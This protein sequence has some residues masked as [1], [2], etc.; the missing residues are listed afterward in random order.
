MRCLQ[1]STAQS[2]QC[3]SV[4]VHSVT[5]SYVVSDRFRPNR[6]QSPQRALLRKQNPIETTIL[7]IVHRLA[8]HQINPNVVYICVRNKKSDR[9]EIVTTSL[10]TTITCLF[11][12][13]CINSEGEVV[14][15]VHFLCKGRGWVDG[16]TDNFGS[17]V[18]HLKPR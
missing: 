12:F 10:A 3:T 17:K 15:M 1:A 2:V 5:C 4:Q 11:D 6:Q 8:S 9:V 14:V 16:G 18:Q 13:A 7:V